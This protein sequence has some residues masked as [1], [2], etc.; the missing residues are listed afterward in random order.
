MN[1]LKKKKVKFKSTCN[2]SAYDF[3]NLLKKSKLNAEAVM[4]LAE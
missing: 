4:Q 2:N 3:F 1:E